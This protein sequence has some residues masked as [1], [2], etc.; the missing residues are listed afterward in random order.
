MQMAMA[1]ALFLLC[2]SVV[3]NNKESVWSERP[4]GKSPISNHTD[5]RACPKLLVFTC[6]I[7]AYLKLF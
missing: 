5:F 4:P 2:V 1:D 3:V 6:N 7:Q